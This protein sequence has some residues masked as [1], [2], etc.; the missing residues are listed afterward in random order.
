MRLDFLST[1]FKFNN[2]SVTNVRTFAKWFFYNPSTVW[3]WF[4]KG[5]IPGF[6]YKKYVY[7][8]LPPKK[9][10]T[11]KP[12]NNI[13]K[14]ELP[15]GRTKVI[16]WNEVV[17]QL[18]LPPL[19]SEFLS[20]TG[21]FLV[22]VPLGNQ[23][24]IN[25]NNNISLSITVNLNT[26]GEG[27]T[28]QEFPSP[29][30]PKLQPLIK[31][32]NLGPF[33]STMEYKYG[34]Y[35]I[36]NPNRPMSIFVPG[37]GTLKSTTKPSAFFELCRL[38]DAA[39]QSRNGSNPGLPAQRNLTTTVSFDTGT[40]AVAASLPVQQVLDASGVPTIEV[41]NYLGTTYTTFDNTG[42]ELGSGNI[43]SAF[44]EMA[45]NL[46]AAEKLVTPTN[47][48]PNNIQI[49]YDIEAGTATVAANLPFSTIGAANGDV[50]IHA[51]D[52]L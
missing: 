6:K 11:E 16:D 40:I 41:V 30:N 37:T 29:I 15:N 9:L 44:L 3:R 4:K 46:A 14:L 42:C 36:Y 25:G 19:V 45:G 17:S 38:L 18:Y 34:Y 5:K 43:I 12:K 47:A 26:P 2:Y 39:E 52:Y 27:A 7:L 1:I 33:P 51:V 21:K 24:N 50:T 23:I 20:N 28:S 10:D 48:Q 35:I 8:I 32:Q 49:Q 31:P 13:V 22:S